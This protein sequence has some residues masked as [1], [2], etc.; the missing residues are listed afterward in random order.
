V[1][2]KI[3]A[4]AGSDTAIVMNQPLQLS[5]QGA[6]FFKWS[7]AFGL[8]NTTISNP[9]A[10]LNDHM[11][12]TM[13]TSTIEGCFAVDTINVKVFKTQPDIFVPNAF[14]PYGRNKLLRPVPVGISSF[15]YFRV[16]NR[17]G[18]LVFHTTEAGKGWDGT[19]NGKVQDGGT[20]VWMVQGKDYTGKTVSKKGTAVLIR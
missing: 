11:T 14:A 1:R 16:F 20:F 3:I 9:V 17:W 6:E 7:P 18:Q 2:Q 15:E 5:G 13:H 4:S 12:Y 8:N 19:V 10:T